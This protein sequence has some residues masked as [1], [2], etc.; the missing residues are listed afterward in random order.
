MATGYQHYMMA[1]AQVMAKSEAK[2]KS[3]RT[4]GR[5][6]S[7][8][9]GVPFKF[10]GQP[11][12][13][14]QCVTVS[15]VIDDVDLE[16]VMTLGERFAMRSGSHFARVYRD[17]TAVRVEFTLPS[18]QWREVRLGKLPHHKE[19]ITVGQRALGPVA[20]LDLENNP[21]KALFG[22]TR[23]GKTYMEAAILVSLARTHGP[24][25]LK[26]LII[27][28]KNDKMFQAFE[29]SS[30]LAAPIATNYEAAVGLLRFA[31]RE[32]EER[33]Y[34]TQRQKVRWFVMIDEVAQLTEVMRE[35]GPMITQ[36]SQMSG[37]L[38]F[39]LVVA[40]QAANPSTFGDK[41]SLA[42]ANFLSRISLQLPDDQAYM[43]LRVKGQHTGSLGSPD[44]SGKGDALAT[45][46]GPVI[47]FRGALVQES[48]FDNLQRSEAP[49]VTPQPDQQAGDR[50]IVPGEWVKPGW[51]VEPD[52][53][54]YAL[55]MRDSATA[56]QKHFGGGMDR[57][58]SVRDY[59]AELRE[60]TKYWLGVRKAEAR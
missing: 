13:G 28:P 43:A 52:Q 58:R 17:L 60:R 51:Q 1:V 3:V 49:L 11:I 54:A 33:K 2:R 32:M 18:S 50:V 9:N 36:L 40:S 41:G 42:Q 34:D 27:N 31:L 55:V 7:L 12:A 38:G 45:N 46:G 8:A 35:S 24:D 19:T 14:P 16:K 39:N 57:A 53:V 21:H 44:G 37:G 30:H 6:V 22:S 29:R 15:L 4:L 5:T 20:R 25:E 48:D 59:A 56:I 47:R 10:L 26:F 23:T